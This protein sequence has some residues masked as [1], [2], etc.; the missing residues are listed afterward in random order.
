MKKL[1]FIFLMMFALSFAFACNETKEFINK[2][3]PEEYVYD[4]VIKYF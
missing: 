3:I 4:Q 1:L 2:F